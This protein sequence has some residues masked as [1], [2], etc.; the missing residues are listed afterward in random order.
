[1]TDFLG[2]AWTIVG[3][4]CMCLDMRMAGE[5]WRLRDMFAY[6][7]SYFALTTVGLAVIRCAPFT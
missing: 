7:G 5:S 1:M 4:A 6:T 3:V 2:S